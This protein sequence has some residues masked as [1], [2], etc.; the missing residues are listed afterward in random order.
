M[1]GCTDEDSS[2]EVLVDMVELEVVESPSLSED[3]L[4]DELL[5]RSPL[6]ELEG[7]EGDPATRLLSDFS[8]AERLG[9]QLASTDEAT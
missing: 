9:E 1:R 5:E 4:L 3:L 8:S 6:W 7:L 2:S